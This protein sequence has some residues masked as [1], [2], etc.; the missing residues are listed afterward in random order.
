MLVY[1][2]VYLL[3]LVLCYVIPA[4]D[5]NGYL[6]KLIIVFIPL[7]LFGALRERFSDQLTYEGIY[8]EIHYMSSFVFDADAHSEVGYQWLCYIMPSFR[9]LLV[10]SAA[11]MCVAYIVFF[12]KN[13]PQKGLIV[14][15]SLLF[16]SGNLSIFFVLSAI[17][18]GIAMSLFI[19]FFS[20]W[21]DRKI[22]PVAIV[23]FVAVTMHTSAIFSL[24]L[25]FLIGRSSPFTRRELY[26]WLAAFI[27]FIF[28]S[29]LSLIH[30]ITPIINSYFDRYDT[31][32]ELGAQR[33]HSIHVLA[34]IGSITLFGLLSS[35]VLKDSPFSKREMSLI[36]VSM[37]FP[38]A[39]VMTFFNARM[40]QYFSPFIVAATS[41][42]YTRVPSSDTKKVYMLFVFAYVGY[43]FY[44]WTQGEWFSYTVYHSILGTL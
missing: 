28:S 10:F 42:I 25:A 13:V 16:L 31:I 9:A 37:L 39:L 30:F 14:A 7:F 36:R 11:L 8:N 4:K 23:T 20:F 40:S 41:I 12:Y 35:F 6:K 5:N 19:L 24:P 2:F 27:F 22:L 44:L 32:L 38:I 3:T 34:A 18:N 43:F 29:T 26:I 17:R 1:L 33:E 21:Q 15:I